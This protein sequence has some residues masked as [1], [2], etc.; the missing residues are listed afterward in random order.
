MSLI[1]VI[2][3]A[4]CLVA[5]QAAAG[6]PQ[7]AQGPVYTVG[8]GVSAPV[9][10]KRVAPQYTPDAMRAKVE[11]T[12]GLECVVETDGST[13]GIRVIKALDPGLDEEAVKALRL[14]TFEPGK[15]DGKPVRV[16]IT[17][18]MTFTLRK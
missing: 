1:S 18:E 6:S 11:G 17:L 2:A 9:V 12:V 5:G 8:D 10:V 13:S 3:M 14:W 7:D 4:S 15:K 16:R